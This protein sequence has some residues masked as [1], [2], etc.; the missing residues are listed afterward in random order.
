VDGA[1]SFCGP[2]AASIVLDKNTVEVGRMFCMYSVESYV[3][4]T[5]SKQK[6][7]CNL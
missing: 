5:R 1:G 6:Y 3:Y 2:S 4:A 7:A